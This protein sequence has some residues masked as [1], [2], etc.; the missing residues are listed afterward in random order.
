[1]WGFILELLKTLGTTAI[2][3]GA[4]AWF[5]KAVITHF[6]S[7]KI[8]VYKIELKSESD[9][10]IEEVKSQLQIMAQEHQIVFSR[11][12]EKRAEIVAESYTL[13]HEVY[14]KAVRLGADVF[15]EGLGTPKPRTKEIFDD[16][17]KFYDFF[18]SRRIYFS[19][20]VCTLM[21]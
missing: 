11:L 7:R 1:M 4:S 14:T 16:C 13:I 3:V 15:H 2:V 8:E 21:D 20:E 19:E 9:K 17:L 18:Q 12:H 5:T 6:L 10:R